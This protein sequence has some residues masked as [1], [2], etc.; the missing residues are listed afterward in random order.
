MQH[1]R[2]LGIVGVGPRGL[3][4]LE[5]FVSALPDLT[6]LHILLF[7]KTGNFGNGQVYDLNQE[8]TNW[9][10]V[11]ERILSI[12][13]REALEVS[14]IHIPSFPSYQE[15]INKK[16][17]KI[18]LNIPD[19]YPPRSKIGNYLRERFLTF[20][21]PLIHSKKATLISEKVENITL[22]SN[23]KLSI[24]TDQETYDDLNE[25]L[26]TIGHQPT[27]LDKQIQEWS[28]F[29]SYN[30]GLKLYTAP[31]PVHDYIDDSQLTENSKIGIRGFGLAM[32][33]VVRAIAEKFGK[34][35]IDD[36]N[37]RA[38]HYSTSY[39]ISG[40]LIPFSLEG[41]PPAPKP[42]NAIL[43]NGFKPT[44]EQLL[45][46]ESKIGNKET[47]QKADSTLFLIEAFSPIAAEKY[48]KL[49]H[50][51]LT[52]SISIKETEHIIKEWLLDQ[53]FQHPTLLTQHQTAAEVMQNFVDMATGKKAVSLDYC[54]G[55]VWRFCQPSIYN[56]LSFNSCDVN[57][58]ADIIALDESTKRYSYGP[59][60]ESMQQMLALVKAQLMSLEVVNNPKITLSSEGWH[61][62]PENSSLI[63]NIMIDSVLDPPKIEAVSAPIVEKLLSNNLM[64]T[65]HDDLGVDTDENGYLK[66]SNINTKIPIALL[67]RLAKG[68]IIGVDAIAECFGDRPEKWAKEAARRFSTY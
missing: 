64:E 54:I 46:F 63:A 32:I 23:G 19:Y 8:E 38:C 5:N 20:I 29:V 24:N 34:F 43:D 53:T 28:H 57:V 39:N 52:K 10:N 51:Y 31:Y 48:H 44:D 3:Y 15:W 21:K 35:V 12:E 26:L 45:E 7:E 50:T 6:N 14:Q 27:K 42:L 40:M 61:F 60:V 1:K 59:P 41:L 36:K 66:S 47:Q 67:G 68:T 9:M 2:K 55:Q 22:K 13:M 49:P 18:S 62:N 65:I 58:F 11:S 56:Q 16:Y 25:V 37:T 4:S 33:D 17:D 30:R